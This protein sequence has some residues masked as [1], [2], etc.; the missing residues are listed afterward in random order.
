MTVEVEGGE[1]AGDALSVQREEGGDVNIRGVPAPGG[2][3]RVHLP[4][5]LGSVQ[6]FAPGA[7]VRQTD[8]VEASVA[9]H[10]GGDVSIGKARYARRV[11][12]CTPL[13]RGSSHR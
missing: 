1:L 11:P 10:A 9:I 3:L 6:V 8:K 12:D 13:E 2:V 5:V 4:Q 7:S